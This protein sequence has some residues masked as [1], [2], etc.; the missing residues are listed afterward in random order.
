MATPI[1][2]FSETRKESLRS[3]RGESTKNIIKKHGDLVRLTQLEGKGKFSYEFGEKY[4]GLIVGHEKCKDS[5]G[6][7][8]KYMGWLWNIETIGINKVRKGWCPG[9]IPEP[10]KQ[11]MKSFLN[12]C[13]FN[14]MKGDVERVKCDDENENFSKIENNKVQEFT[15]NNEN[16][17]KTNVK[18]EKIDSDLNPSKKIQISKV[19]SQKSVTNVKLHDEQTQYDLADFSNNEQEN[20]LRKSVKNS[21]RITMSNKISNVGDEERRKTCDN[22]RKTL[23]EMQKKKCDEKIRRK[24]IPVERTR[25]ENKLR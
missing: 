4:P 10:V 7:V 21:N 22:P 1:G 23:I 18:D 12:P 14:D 5:G 17:I 24:T 20:A 9:A 13:P 8:P 6:L 11:I 15:E 2:I 25:S 16:E 19:S 3:P